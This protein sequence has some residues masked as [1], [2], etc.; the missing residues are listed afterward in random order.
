VT[1]AGNK[2]SWMN[3]WIYR[4]WHT[5]KALMK[6][7]TTG[8]RKRL[9]ILIITFT[10]IKYPLH[11]LCVDCC[12]CNHYN[13]TGCNETEL[14]VHRL[15]NGSTIIIFQHQRDGKHECNLSRETLFSSYKRFSLFNIHSS[16]VTPH[17]TYFNI[18][19]ICSLPIDFLWFSE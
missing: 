6:Y 2:S 15:P 12:Q 17:T 11:E 8:T 19:N 16:V 1:L 7:G 14:P 5:D 3:L 10:I 4:L 18:E 13:V 9:R